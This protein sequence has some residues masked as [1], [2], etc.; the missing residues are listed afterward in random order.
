MRSFFVRRR[1]RSAGAPA[2]PGPG[3]VVIDAKENA[4]PKERHLRWKQT[5]RS[6]LVVP[7]PVTGF[8][9]GVAAGRAGAAT[10]DL[11]L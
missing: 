4:A 3:R 9:T 2:N 11:T 5:A 7:P 6:Y 1:K 10:P 8:L